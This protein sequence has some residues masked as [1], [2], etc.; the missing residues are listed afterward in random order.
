MEEN[1]S[2]AKTAEEMA[3]KIEEWKRKY[4]K[5]VYLLRSEEV[6]DCPELENVDIYCKTPEREELSRFIKDAT[7]G[8]AL[9]AQNNFF[10]NCLLDPDPSFIKTIAD[11]KPGIII[12]LGNKL[13]E[14]TGINQGFTMRKL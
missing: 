2:L 4:P 5:G 13:Q 12:A 1:K 7:G 3:A 11:K 14:L 10:Y 9:K 8:D 6:D